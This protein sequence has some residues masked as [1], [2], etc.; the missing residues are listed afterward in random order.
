[1]LE[2]PR[3]WESWKGRVV[4]AIAIDGVRTWTEIRD[5][6]GLSPMSLNKVLSELFNAD[7]LEKKGES[8]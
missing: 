6:T 1:M 2:E 4:K 8:E 3:Y 5:S 7:M